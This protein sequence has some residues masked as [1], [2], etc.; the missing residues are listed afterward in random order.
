[1]A[2][3]EAERRGFLSGPV[4]VIAAVL[5]VTPFALIPVFALLFWLTPPPLLELYYVFT[6]YVFGSIVAVPLGLVVLGFS[7]LF[8]MRKPGSDGTPPPKP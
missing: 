6:Y 1:M 3:I 8:E 4:Q 7:F 2:G 5:I